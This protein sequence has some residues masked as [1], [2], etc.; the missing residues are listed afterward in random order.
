MDLRAEEHPLYQGRPS[1]RALMT[2][3]V[4][5]IVLAALV[6]VVL[7]ILADDLGLSIAIAA[8]IVALTFVIGFVRR[9]G[10]KY[11]LTTQRLRITRG[12]VRKSVQ[13]TRLDRVQNV[14]YNQGVLDRMFGVGTV[15]FDTAVTDDSE[16]RFEWINNP[17]HVVRRV[18]EATHAASQ[19]LPPSSSGPPA[20]EP[21]AS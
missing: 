18:D 14:N 2:F 15:D 11:L 7:G 3:Y 13:E 6:V 8:V 4:G 1:W 9:V 17:E 5:G 12:I 21:T 20:T 16:F 19:Q 10:T